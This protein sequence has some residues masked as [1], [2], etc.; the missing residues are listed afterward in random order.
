MRNKT[1]E[2]VV[3]RPILPTFRDTVCKDIVLL[4]PYIVFFDKDFVVKFFVGSFT[5]K[6]T[7]MFNNCYKSKRNFW[8][9]CATH[10]LT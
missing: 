8:G 3:F 10:Q 4:H 7:H 5:V 9:K 2:V 6:T 1:Y